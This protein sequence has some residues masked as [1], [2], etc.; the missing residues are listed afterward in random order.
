MWEN[1]RK[2]DNERC[3]PKA[4][5]WPLKLCFWKRETGRK[6]KKK[7]Q[8]QKT[9]KAAGTS[10]ALHAKHPKSQYSVR[11]NPG[12]FF[13]FF[14]FFLCEIS[15]SPKNDFLDEWMTALGDRNERHFS[16]WGLKSSARDGIGGRVLLQHLQTTV[17][18]I[19]D[20]S[21]WGIS[22]QHCGWTLHGLLQKSGRVRHLDTRNLLHVCHLRKYKLIPTVN[23][24]FW[25]QI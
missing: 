17:R 7:Q 14:F 21:V 8:Q 15:G 1:I 23:K 4:S 11:S 18:L 13:F 6:R 9:P 25:G 10:A 12:H 16:P 19:F 22:Q 3:L 2:G 5:A 20:E 24:V